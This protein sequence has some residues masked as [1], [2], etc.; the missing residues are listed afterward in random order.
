LYDDET[1]QREDIGYAASLISRYAKK[2]EG[3]PT[4]GNIN[5]VD[6]VEQK[7]IYAEPLE[8]SN[9]SSWII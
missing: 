3:K 4:A 9:F 2:L 7:I 6:K 5:V 1:V 8:D